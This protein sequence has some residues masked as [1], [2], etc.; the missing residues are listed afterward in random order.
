M[1]NINK[2]KMEPLVV[3][4]KENGKFG[5]LNG[6]N[7][8]NILRIMG[9]SELSPEMYNYSDNSYNKDILKIIDIEDD[10]II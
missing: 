2:I 10:F 5:I 7:R 1:I 8:F 4:K 3:Y 9:I 6:H